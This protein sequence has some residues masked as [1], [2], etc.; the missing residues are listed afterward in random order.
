[1]AVPRAAAAKARHLK[2]GSKSHVE[3]L[4]SFF[5]FKRGVLKKE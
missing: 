5:P 2:K 1:M 4:D 3:L